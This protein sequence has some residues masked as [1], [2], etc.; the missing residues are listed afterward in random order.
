MTKNK[1]VSALISQKSKIF[2]CKIKSNRRVFQLAGVGSKNLKIKPN[3]MA[4]YPH[5]E[6]VGFLPWDKWEEFTDEE[7]A[8]VESFYKQLP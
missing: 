6:L 3:R 1:I 4:K 2:N 5:L 7:I 8:L